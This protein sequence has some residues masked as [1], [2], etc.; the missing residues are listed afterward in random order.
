METVLH[1][2]SKWMILMIHLK[3]AS[4]AILATPDK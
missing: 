2:Q 1:K 4:P 3:T